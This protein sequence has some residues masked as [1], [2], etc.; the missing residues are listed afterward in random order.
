MLYVNNRW[1]HGFGQWFGRFKQ[2]A[3]IDK[4]A[5][6]KSFH[7]FR[8]TLINQLKQGGADPQYV[9][10][11]VEHKQGKDITWD[12]YGKAFRPPKL[13]EKVIMKLDYTVDLSHLKASKYV[14]K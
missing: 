6:M 5:G 8:H 2:R 9:K 14:V 7:S 11:F 3:G 1:G 13:M 12:L 10:E 4:T